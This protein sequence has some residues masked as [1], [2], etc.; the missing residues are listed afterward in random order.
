MEALLAI[1]MR[2]I[3]GTTRVIRV[4]RAEVLLT[5][6]EAFNLIEEMMIDKEE[7]QIRKGVEARTH[8]VGVE[9]EES[10]DVS[11]R[12]SPQVPR[13]RGGLPKTRVVGVSQ[14]PPCWGPPKA[15]PRS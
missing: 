15:I 9:G 5:C 1:N 2:V 14:N 6:I 12:A 4:R 10:R 11:P 8:A 3:K 7:L 13:S